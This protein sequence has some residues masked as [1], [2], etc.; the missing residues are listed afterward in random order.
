MES[1][2]KQYVKEVH[3]RDRLKR[4]IEISQSVISKLSSDI[5]TLS[6][7]VET[8]YLEKKWGPDGTEKKGVD[9]ETET[10]AIVEQMKGSPEL[11]ED[12]VNSLRQTQAKLNAEITEVKSELMK[13]REGM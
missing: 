13:L 12:A 5:N 11:V 1:L 10:L 8:Y 2:R 7:E 6:K 3:E 4:D 9:P